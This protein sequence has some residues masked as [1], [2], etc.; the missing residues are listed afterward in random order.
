MAPAR[1]LPASR[2]RCRPAST[3]WTS[4]PRMQRLAGPRALSPGPAVDTCDSSQQTRDDVA[5]CRRVR[6]RT[7]PVEGLAVGRR[8]VS[9]GGLVRPHLS[10]DGSGWASGHRRFPMVCCFGAPSGPVGAG[11]TTASG[12]THRPPFGTHSIRSTSPRR[13]PKPATHSPDRC[14]ASAWRFDAASAN[15]VALNTAAAKATA[16][17]DVA[18]VTNTGGISGRPSS[19]R[20]RDAPGWEHRSVPRQ[21][22]S[23]RRITRCRHHGRHQGRTDRA[24]PHRL[25]VQPGSWAANCPQSVRKVSAKQ[26]VPNAG[27][28]PAPAVTPDDVAGAQRQSGVLQWGVPALTGALVVVSAYARDQQRASEASKASRFSRSPA[29]LRDS[30][31]WCP[32]PDDKFVRTLGITGLSKSMVSE[33]PP[34]LDEQVTAFR[35]RPLDLP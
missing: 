32:S 7:T 23:Q 5:T 25:R 10:L 14:R 17:T 30:C 15:T 22:C 11:N 21:H 31:S 29:V 2:H 34:H 1:S 6:D 12:Y 26:N 3:A 4:P 9:M 28:E 18:A 20:D 16:P 19:G 24:S 13:A 33:M 27:T 8:W 35:T